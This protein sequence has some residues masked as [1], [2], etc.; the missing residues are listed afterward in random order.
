MANQHAS[1]V[2][3]YET[4]EL[5]GQPVELLL[6]QAM[7]GR[8]RQ[9]RRAYMQLPDFRSM[10]QGLDIIGRRKDGS[11]FPAEVSLSPL[12]TPEG[13]LVTA[14]VRDITER[15]QAEAALRQ[16]ERQLAQAQ[17]MAQ[18]G[19]WRWEVAA[20]QL[21]WS[22]VLCEI[23]GVEPP[24]PPMRLSEFLDAIHPQDRARVQ[25]VIS[26]ARRLGSPF[27]YEHRIRR[28]DGAVRAL[29]SRGEVLRGPNGQPLVISAITQDLTQRKAI[30]D[31]LRSSREQLR[32]LS[33]HLQ[34][35][36]EEERAR[37]SREIHDELGGTLTG[38]KMDVSRLAKNADSLTPPELRQRA[39]DITSMIDST[40]QTVRRIASDLR[41]GILDDFGLAAAIEW[42]LQEFCS[43]AGLE[44][45]Y[46]A[47][48]DELNLDPASST[49]LFRLFQETL[50][51]VARHAQATH[52][53]AQLEVSADELRLEVRDNGRGISS[54]EIG[55]SKSLGLL[56]MRERVQQLHGQLSITGSPGQGTTVVIR[57]PL[58]LAAAAAR[59]LDGE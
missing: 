12:Q 38:L 15:K 3:G 14:S 28:P 7:K 29:Y 20:D 17:Q 50:T 1:V 45:D 19:S 22:D 36:R 51:N 24:Q 42:Q 35:A 21:T 58:A 55:N 46:E 43:R 31:E 40:V 6:P 39:L 18:V 11:L 52:V 30:E 44:Y 2:F 9:H 27:E 10:G 26:E 54:G 53:T 56:G 32:Q 4:I 34:A 48:T 8:H 25:A 5:L 37:M 16:S 33:S 49:A 57:V 47:N 13:V 59:S 41:P 23:H